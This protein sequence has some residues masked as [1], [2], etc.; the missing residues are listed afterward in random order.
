MIGK[1]KGFTTLCR[2]NELSQTFFAYN[3]KIHRHV[4][5]KEVLSFNPHSDIITKA[6]YSMRAAPFQHRLFKNLFEDD[7]AE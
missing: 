2:K 5:C 4:L 7:D 3:C 6:I 1:N